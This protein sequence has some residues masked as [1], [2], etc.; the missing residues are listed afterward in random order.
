MCIFPGTPYAKDSI[1][2]VLAIDSSGSMKK[3]DPM[4]LRIPAAKLFMSLLDKD[5][6]AAIISFSGSSKPL[7]EFTPVNNEENKETLFKAAEQITSDGLYTNLYDAMNSGIKMLPGDNESDRSQ[8]IVL[9]SDGMMDVGDPDEDTKLLAKIKTE[10]ISVLKEKS[11]KVYTIAF[12]DQSDR[13][14]LERVSKRTGGF[15]NLALTDKDLHVIFTSIFESLKTPDM[16]PMD[17]NEFVIDNSIEEVTIVATKKDP[18]VKIQLKDP[19]GRIYAAND[20]TVGVKWFESNKFEMVTV[21]SPP[22]GKWEIL[23]STGKNNKAYIITNLKMRT[24]FD[25]LYT[26]Y[27]KP[28]DIKIWLEKEGSTIKEQT[29][30]DTID[31]YMEVTKPDGKIMRLKPFNKGEGVFLRRVAPFKAGNYK[32]KIIAKGKTFE[33]EKSF[34]F[35]VAGVQESKEDIEI[36]R[37]E[38]KMKEEKKKEEKEKHE[39]KA[40]EV[41]ELDEETGSISWGKVIVQFLLINIV[42]A[43]IVFIYLKRNILSKVV[44]LIRK[45]K[46]E[47]NVQ[48]EESTEESQEEELEVDSSESVELEPQQ[49]EESVEAEDQDAKQEDSEEELPVEAQRAPEPEEDISTIELEDGDEESAEQEVSEEET[50]DEEQNAPEPEEDISKIELEDEDEESAE[51]EVS[52]EDTPDEEQNAPEPEEDISKIELEDEDEEPAEQEDS[53][54]ET[55][56]E[57]QSAPEPEE[58]I[59]KIKLEDGDA[60]EDTPDEE[61]LKK[62][63]ESPEEEQVEEKEVSEDDWAEAMQEQEASTED[64]PKEEESSEEEQAEEKDVSEDDWAEAMQEQEAST[65]DQPK[66]DESSEEEQAEEKDVSEDDWAEAMQ[67]QEASTEDQPKE[68]ESPEEEQV[69]EKEVSEDDWA[70]AM[71]EQEASTEDQPKEDESS[72]EEQAEEKDVNKEGK[73]NDQN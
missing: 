23:F 2:V 15:Y 47:E 58:D 14:L 3:T 10:L 21:I 69:K 49:E 35:N 29:V 50:P 17:K 57:D 72:E 51:Q 39:E 12:T 36:E 46:K 64:Q 63:E 52:E 56:D 1:D 62:N 44:D 34:V 26:T 48:E 16:L 40:E 54:E 68:D 7:I 30:L 25:K 4:S 53:V 59:S 65:E 66:E 5:D 31:I 55:A 43:G 71:Q 37:H 24:N 33:R 45:K 27:G 8:I 28:L 61:P 32:M 42:I 22:A 20:K 70:E 67:E 38:K 18:S 19:M 41:D 9:M 6:R 73:N 13:K 60:E 11:V